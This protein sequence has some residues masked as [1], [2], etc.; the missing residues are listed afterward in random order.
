MRQSFWY[1]TRSVRSPHIA[2]QVIDAFVRSS[3]TLTPVCYWHPHT[4]FL[5]Q[6]FNMSDSSDAKYSERC[7]LSIPTRWGPRGTQFTMIWTVRADDA[8]VTMVSCD[9][10]L[11]KVHRKNLEMYTEGFPGVDVSVH[12]EIVP[13]TETAATLELLFQYMYR[14]RQPDLNRLEPEQ[15]AKLAEAA[16]KYQVYSAIEVCKMR[17]Q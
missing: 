6:G 3:R 16:E 12:D 11:F 4:P 9:G 17:M 7:K 10:V 14:Q 8:D 5:A 13:L 1:N 15:L 2:G